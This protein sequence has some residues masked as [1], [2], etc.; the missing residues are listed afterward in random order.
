MPVAFLALI[1]AGSPAPM[2]TFFSSQDERSVAAND[3]TAAKAAITK[4]ES[5]RAMSF[6]SFI[7]FPP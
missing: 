1:S 4:T 3:G 7:V 5:M 6:L 2:V